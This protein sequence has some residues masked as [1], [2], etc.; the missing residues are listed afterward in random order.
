[1]KTITIKGFI[2]WKKPQWKGD[3]EFTFDSWD[4]SKINDFAHG[5]VMVK[6]HEFTTDIPDN[7]NP[8]PGLVSQLETE[9]RLLK[10]K[11]AKDLMNIE[12]SISKLT[13]IAMDEV[14]A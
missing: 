8:I 11:F 1:M 2:H 7:F 9:K 13:C 4:Y 6:P 10:A 12:A 5:R 14:T 3:T